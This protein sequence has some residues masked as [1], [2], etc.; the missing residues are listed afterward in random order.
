[1][2]DILAPDLYNDFEPF[3]KLYT[4]SGN[5][6]FIPEGQSGADGANR[7][8]S[9]FVN[10]NAICYSAFGIESGGPGGRRGAAGADGT[11]PPDPFAQ[12][13]AILDFLAP[14]ILDNQGKDTIA[15]LEPMND[16]NAA[17]QT[18]KMGDYT[19]TIRYGA[20][21]GGSRG[22]ARRGGGGGGGGSGATNTSPARLVINSGPGDYW[23]V[24]GPMNVTFT[25][26]SPER[27]SAVMGS[28]DEAL[29]VDGRWVAGRRLNG[30][31]TS[32]NKNWQT[33][34]SFGI[35]HYTVFQRQ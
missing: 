2:L 12:T 11:P 34:G 28:F 9:A 25:P 33:M 24:G 10:H 1:M 16:T 32:N 18:L 13:Y 21:A 29:N 26:N 15:I 27:G 31:E 20:G 5:P 19:L 17:P 4:R 3:A 8:I 23:F 30:D 7:A 14:V 6:L 35:Y 22:G